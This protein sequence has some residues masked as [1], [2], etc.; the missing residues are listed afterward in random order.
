M[1]F[2]LTYEQMLL[3]VFSEIFVKRVFA[4]QALVTTKYVFGTFLTSYPIF[5]DSNTEYLRWTHYV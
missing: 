2:A 3:D 5:R 4:S 1:L